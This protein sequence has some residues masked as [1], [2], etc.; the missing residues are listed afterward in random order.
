MH[1]DIRTSSI[2]WIV[3]LGYVVLCGLLWAARWK[4]TGCPGF[5]ILNDSLSFPEAL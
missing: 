1:A 2:G 4:R 3:A 5:G